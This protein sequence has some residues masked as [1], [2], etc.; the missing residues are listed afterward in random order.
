M[1]ERE[2]QTSKEWKDTITPKYKDI[3]DEPEQGRYPDIWNG[4][5]MYHGRRSGA[6]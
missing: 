1:Q 4:T 6:F 3:L 5:S 2:L